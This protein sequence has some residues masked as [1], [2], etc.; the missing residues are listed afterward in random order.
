MPSGPSPSRA[1]ALITRLG[2]VGVAAAHLA[3][4]SAETGVLQIG[5]PRRRTWRPAALAASQR[6]E[7]VRESEDGMPLIHL[8]AGPTGVGK[9]AMATDLARAGG[10]P[11]VVADRIQCFTDLATTSARAGAEQPGAS[12]YWLG[13]RTALDGDYPAEEAAQALIHQVFELG[14]EHPLVIIEGG[15]IS[16]LQHLAEHLP[17][18]PWRLTVCLLPLP[19]RARYLTTLTARAREMLMPAPPGRSLLEELSALWRI[20]RA[21]GFAASVNGLEAALEW[22]AKYS[23]DPAQVDSSEISE[24]IKERLAHMIAV[25]HL[26]HGVLQS[27]VFRE[28]FSGWPTGV[29]YRK[30]PAV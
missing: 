19:D 8:I 5:R 13:D 26:E 1:R 3:F 30:E 17:D 14:G 25:R 24:E 20:P 12:R 16:L 21:R 28:L 22:C 6:G 9:S 2:G 18:L 4:T 27:S 11:I 7:M 10:A 15:S 29:E 23:L